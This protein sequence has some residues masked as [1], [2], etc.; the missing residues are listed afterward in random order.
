MYM[1]DNAFLAG[2]MVEQELAVSIGAVT[3]VVDN[4]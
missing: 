4:K 3:F 2:P 1:N